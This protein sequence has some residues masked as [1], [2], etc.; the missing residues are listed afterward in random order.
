MRISVFTSN[1]KAG[2]QLFCALLGA[3]AAALLVAGSMLPGAEAR[4]ARDPVLI[5]AG[6]IASCTSTADGAT[7]RLLDGRRGTVFT[8]GDNAY[9]SGAAAEF[10]NCY[11]PTWGRHKNRTRPS[12]GDHEYITA[13]ASGYFGY[14]GARAGASGKGY[15]SYDRGRWHIVVLNSNCGEVGGCSTGSAQLRWL[16]RDLIR[17]PAAC[18]IAYWHQARFSSGSVHGNDPTTAPFWRALY[19]RRADVIVSGHEHVY[20]RFARQTPGGKLSRLGI[21][22]F[23]V[24]TGGRGLYTFG[25][26]R[27]NSQVRGAAH[28]VLR[29][30]LHPDSYDWRFIPV[31]GETFTDSGHTG[32]RR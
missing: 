19:N 20:E 11:D 25:V 10:A 3:I 28:G 24:G 30:T 5:G 22:Q 2:V 6:D 1:T 21:R 4:T 14:F 27:P 29:L 17:N 32:C 16:Q 7:A 23:V 12:L 15:Y 13:G 8:A 26:P 18:T 31:A 9:E